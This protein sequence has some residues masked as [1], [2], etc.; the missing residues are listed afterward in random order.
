MSDRGDRVMRHAMMIL[1]ISERCARG[2][3][4][5][6]NNGGT[7]MEAVA[8]YGG[9]PCRMRVVWPRTR[10]ASSVILRGLLHDR[11]VAEAVGEAVEHAA[12]SE[13]RL[14]GDVD[15]MVE[16]AVEAERA[17]HERRVEAV[18]AELEEVA[19]ETQDVLNATRLAAADRAADWQRR[20]EAVRAEL[21]AAEDAA[22]I[23]DACCEQCGCHAG[24][25]H[26]ALEILTAPNRTPLS[27]EA[28]GARRPLPPEV[29]ADA[30]Q[31]SV[32][33]ELGGLIGSKPVCTCAVD[34]A[35]YCPAHRITK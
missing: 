10:S 26:R 9:D 12:E 3:R 22:H 1:E 33:V 28:S 24:G 4:V 16:E 20:V 7:R 13:R 8:H 18:R 2:H 21:E 14:R 6:G 30:R 27:P 34:E 5:W 19:D 25:L 32:H 11:L 29:L 23:D 31:E 15:R 35:R 17:E